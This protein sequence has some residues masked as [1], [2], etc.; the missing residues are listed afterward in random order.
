MR[1]H[2]FPISL[3]FFTVLLPWFSYFIFDLAR[4]LYLIGLILLRSVYFMH[5]YSN[6]ISIFLIS[7][8]SQE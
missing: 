3:T 6:D 7:N 4:T 8:E 1:F 5:S 2:A